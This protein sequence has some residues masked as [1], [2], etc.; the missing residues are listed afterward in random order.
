MIQSAAFVGAG[1]IIIAMI[2][3]WKMKETFGKDLDFEER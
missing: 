1:T 2:A 3:L